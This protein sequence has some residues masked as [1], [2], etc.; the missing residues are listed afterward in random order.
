ME[1]YRRFHRVA[2][3]RGVPEDEVAR[4]GEFLRF[5][6]WANERDG[7]PVG[8]SG[9][10]PRLPLGMEWP[11]SEAGPLP[12]VASVD[13]AALPRVDGLALPAD[14]SLLFFLHHEDAHEAFDVTGE[15]EHAR[16]V[17][18]PVGAETV[19]AEE[20][21]HAENV[22]CNLSLGFVGREFEFFATVNAELPG[23]L[24]D[25]DD[26]EDYDGSRTDNQEHLARDLPH[27][28]ELCAL[29]AELWPQQGDPGFS[30]GG[31]TS[32][33]GEL[34]TGFMYT[35][36]EISIAEA[37]LEAREKAGELVIPPAESHLLLEQETL[38]V[39]REWVPLAQFVPEDVYIG[40]FLIRRDD[41]AAG[42][43]D[44]ALSFTAFTE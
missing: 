22:F 32:G 20:P 30:L 17:Y 37:S 39:M 31:Y 21:E 25:Y 16:V 27:V 14:G 19:T 7:V 1:Y 38:R 10:L 36:P 6:I 18:V 9:G 43:F 13:C 2:V 15:Q 4:F 35:T 28:R 8:R 42:R 44:R 33:I 5:A 29:V 41:L 26:F 24:G 11:S 3:E 23:W 40:R 34:A 12:F